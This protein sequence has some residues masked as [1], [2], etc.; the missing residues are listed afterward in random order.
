MVEH[1]GSSSAK[2]I[3]YELAPPLGKTMAEATMATRLDVFASFG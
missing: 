3:M 1:Q 2:R